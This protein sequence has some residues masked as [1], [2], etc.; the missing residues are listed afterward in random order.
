MTFK[1][2]DVLERAATTLQDSSHVRW[3]LT[4]LHR[5]LND[6]LREIVTIKPNALSK[7]VNLSLAEGTKQSLPT[8]YTILSRVSRNMASASVGGEAIRT[9]DSRSIMDSYMPGWQSE[10]AIPFAK[11]VVH[12]IH[13]IADPKTFYVVPGNNGTGIIEAVV[14]ALPTPSPVPGSPASLASYTDNVDMPDIYLNALTDYVLYRAYSK[15]GRVA[16]SSAR[17]QAHFQLFREGVT[18]FSNAEIGMSLST[19]ASTTQQ[20]QE[21]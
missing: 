15:D 4:E 11:A 8:T 20:A 1:S 13:D 6:G 16:G 7:T 5:Y 17:A 9:L 2:Q 10:A 19:H 14:G 3:P 21:G 18:G 12:V